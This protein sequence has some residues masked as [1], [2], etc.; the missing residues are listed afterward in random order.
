ML[1][2]SDFSIRL[3]LSRLYVYSEKIF[4]CNIFYS[5]IYDKLGYEDNRIYVAG[6]ENREENPDSHGHRLQ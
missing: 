6:Y 2:A 5:A 3:K 4:G 1:A